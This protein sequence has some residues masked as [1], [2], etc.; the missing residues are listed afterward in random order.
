MRLYNSMIRLSDFTSYIKN[1]AYS[2]T[3]GRTSALFY[4]QLIEKP[5]GNNILV[6]SPHFDDEVIG[7]GGTLI[8]HVRAGDQVSVIYLTDGTNGTPD[9]TDKHEGARIRKAESIHATRILGITD[10]HFLNEIEG[11][12]KSNPETVPALATLLKKIKPD[13]VYIPWFGENHSD[14]IKANNIFMRVWQQ[15]PFVCTVCAYEVWTPLPPT[16]IVNIGDVFDLKMKALECFTSQ[17]KHNDYRRTVRG[18]NMYN[19]RYCLNGESYA[20]AFLCMDIEKYKKWAPL[21]PC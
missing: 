8:K 17:L 13:V 21:F 19:T 5:E 14:H 10:L 4:P 9:I 12:T 18:L 15:E 11:Q 3:Q 2:Y 6:I 7:C 1:L 16:S 20:E